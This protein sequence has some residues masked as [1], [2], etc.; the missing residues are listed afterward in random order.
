MDQMPRFWIYMQIGIVICVLISA[1]IVI[2]KT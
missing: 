2:V 1:V